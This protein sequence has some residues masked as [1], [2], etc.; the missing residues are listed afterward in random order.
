VSG[1]ESDGA[2]LGVAPELKAAPIDEKVVDWDW[3]QAASS[4][5]RMRRGV[6]R[7]RNRAGAMV[8]PFPFTRG[9]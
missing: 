6:S 1:Y 3:P 4:N 5:R 7:D 8:M 9:S 2:A